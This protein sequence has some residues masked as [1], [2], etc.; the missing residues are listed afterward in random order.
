M[1]E[2][3]VSDVL[4]LFARSQPLLVALGDERRQEIIVRLLTAGTALSVADLTGLLGLSQPAVSHHL[5]I[6]R[7]ARLLTVRRQGTQR[8]YSLNADHYPEVLGPL[9][10]LVDTIA[11]CTHPAPDQTGCGDR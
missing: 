7:D 4:A 8:L 11:A 3:A 10:D 2:T 9:R 5:R 1:A 6:L